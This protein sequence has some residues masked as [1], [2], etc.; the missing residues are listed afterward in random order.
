[1]LRRIL[2]LSSLLVATA[3]FAAAATANDPDAPAGATPRWLPCENWVMYHWL[4]FDENEFLRRSSITRA[5]LK[6]WLY[7]SDTNTVGELVRR[8]GGDPDLIVAALLERRRGRV[9]DRQFTELTRRATALMTQSHLAQHVFF[10]LFH[11][12]AVALESR[13]IFNVGTGDYMRARMSG[14]TPREIAEHGG[15][16]VRTAVRRAMAVL[17]RRQDAGIAKGWTTHVQAAN[18]LA[19]QRAWTAGWLTQTIRIER[20][21]GFPHGHRPPPGTRA[22]R[23]CR[24]MTGTNHERGSHD[25][26]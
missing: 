13:W 8:N 18:F 11:D 12:P 20:R 26:V 15:V 24:L 22:Q 21:H 4:P 2:I 7:R 10:H 3:S 16:P 23:A 9:P 1:M 25:D 14:W 5:Q 17:R 19:R 6:R